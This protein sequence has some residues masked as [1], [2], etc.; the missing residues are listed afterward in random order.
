[1]HARG[2]AIRNK[3][4]LFLLASAVMLCSIS[5]AS[6]TDVQLTHNDTH[7]FGTIT[8]AGSLGYYEFKVGTPTGIWNTGDIIQTFC[9]SQN[10]FLSGN[11]FLLRDDLHNLPTP[12]TAM[13]PLNAVRLVI[14]INELYGN[15]TN[16]TING[17]QTSANNLLTIQN[18]IWLMLA[19]GSDALVSA[20]DSVLATYG[21]TLAGYIGVHGGATFVG[22]HGLDQYNNGQDQIY[23]TPGTPNYVFDVPVPAGAVLAGLGIC[24]IGGFSY[25]RR[26][27]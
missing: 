2:L 15:G 3:V 11:N 14:L 27:K 1:M 23:W 12:G 25:L 21:G 24:C 4:H 8:G 18:S 13:G 7:N 9:I 26:R 16:A 20:V 19:G 17:Y 22:T 6:A 10:N 5:T